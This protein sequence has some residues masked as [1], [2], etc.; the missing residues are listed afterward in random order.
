[1][2][3]DYR[4]PEDL[5]SDE[6]FLSW[7][8]SPDPQ[9]HLEWTRWMRETPDKEQLVREAV[10]LLESTVIREKELPSRQLQSA[11][12]ALMQKI[13]AAEPPALRGRLSRWRWIAAAS[14]IVI[15]AGAMIVMRVRSAGEQLLTTP[16][17]KLLV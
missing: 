9:A 12:L 11:E 7:Y 6:S 4:E 8:F 16:Y 14:I 10:A 3:K 13:G 5:L 15:L 1:M 2:P 17:G